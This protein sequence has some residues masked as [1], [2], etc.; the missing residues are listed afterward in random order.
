V[1]P[2]MKALGAGLALIV[3]TNGIALGGAA[4]N[5]SGPPTSTLTLTE[6]ELMP[7]RGFLSSRDENSGIS[8]RLAWRTARFGLDGEYDDG[9]SMMYG[10]NTE[11]P[12]LDRE[13][14][15]ALG[16]DVSLP[17]DAPD[18]NE[19]YENQRSRP[20][21]IVLELDG[22][23]Y[24]VEV[25]RAQQGLANAQARA[26]ANPGDEGATRDLGYF[27]KNL[28]REQQRSTRLFAVDAGTDYAAFRQKYADAARYVILA[29]H[30]DI[31]FCRAEDRTPRLCGRISD[32]EVPQVN[33]R[34]ELRSVFEGATYKYYSD[35]APDV[36]FAAVVA[37]GQRLEPWIVSAERK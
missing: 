20:A 10:H 25:K 5:R 33:V 11:S 22:P 30:V 35:E 31:G 1:T 26:A 13:R 15:A 7:V 37:W 19:H 3:V 28:E 18:A 9:Y 24:A 29:G 2:R 17:V 23:A 8:M 36:R 4:Y 32:I 16:F 14:L 6:R 34:Y 27:R 21:L 12:W